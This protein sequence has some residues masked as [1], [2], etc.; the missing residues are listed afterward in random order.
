MIA[1]ESVFRY[2]LRPMLSSQSSRRLV[3]VA[4]SAGVLMAVPAGVPAVASSVAGGSPI[5]ASSTASGPQAQASLRSKKYCDTLYKHLR[6]TNSP[7]VAKFLAQLRGC[8]FK[9]AKKKH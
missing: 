8:V 3:A 7:K 2:Q 1:Y 6:R 4:L 9:T 5:V